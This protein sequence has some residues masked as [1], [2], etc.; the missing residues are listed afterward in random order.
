MAD[1]LKDKQNDDKLRQA[2]DQYDEDKSGHL[3]LEEFEEFSRDFL[4]VLCQV[5]IRI[6]LE[7]LPLYNRLFNLINQLHPA[8]C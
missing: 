1:A 5:D 4:N 3:D 7:F 2:F 8:T 6:L